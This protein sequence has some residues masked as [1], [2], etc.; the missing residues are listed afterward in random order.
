MSDPELPRPL[1]F[2]VVT[3][4]RAIVGALILAGI[5]VN[6]A[7]VIG[8]YVFLQPLIWA[9]ETMVYIMVW[10]VFMGAVL[11]S[12]EGQHLKMDFFSIML[13]SPWKEVINGIAALSF[14]AVCVFVIPQTWTV[15]KLVWNFGQR[16]VVAEIPTVI[17]HFALLLGFVLMFLAVA[18][19]FRSYVKGEFAG[20]IVQKYG[21]D[22]Q[23][24]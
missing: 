20:E 14:L 6:F 5:A 7:N 22:D 9:D 23:D 15:V 1:R 11:V 4:P 8:R 24:D 3:V 13:P 16:S 17:P 21:G 10:T 19:R 18:L 2:V 12:F